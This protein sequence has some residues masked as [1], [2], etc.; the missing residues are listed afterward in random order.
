MIKTKYVFFEKK[1]T[2]EIK[3][4]ETIRDEKMVREYL[5]EIKFYL[6]MMKL[7]LNNTADIFP[8]KSLYIFNSPC[9]LCDYTSLCSETYTD[10]FKTVKPKKDKLFISPTDI[11]QFEICPRAW[12]YKKDGIYS[13]KKRGIIEA[14]TCLHFAIESFLLEKKDPVKVFQ[15]KWDTINF[16]E[17]EFS[18]RE[19]PELI[20]EIATILLEQFP[21]FW[22]KQNL[23]VL[24][25]EEKTYIEFANN[26][27]FS[28]QW[29][30]LCKEENGDEIIIDFKFSSP[31]GE[32]SIINWLHNSDQITGYA[33]CYLYKKN[34][35]LVKTFI[36][37][38]GFEKNRS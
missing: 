8:K 9:T 4:F 5:Y 10:D 26:V 27:V 22:E 20:K 12:G 31:N 36:K 6:P 23:E 24:S 35:E 3:V 32:E 7:A 11:I 25:M 34:P 28:G 38:A 14:G 21:N 2:P 1:S 19:S 29:D 15:E 18:K 16:E 37:E 13:L 30:L 33:L 17:L